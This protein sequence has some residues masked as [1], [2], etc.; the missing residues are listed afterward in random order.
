VRRQTQYRYNP[1]N[2]SLTEQPLD[3]DFLARAIGYYQAA[4]HL[5]EHNR[6]RALTAEEYARALQ[7][8][9]TPPGS[10]P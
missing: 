7:P 8:P 2:F 6:Y 3:H 5:Y 4:N 10:K 1:T 9:V